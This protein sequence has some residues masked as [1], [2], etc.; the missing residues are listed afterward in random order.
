[1]TARW[2]AWLIASI[3]N[4]LGHCATSPGNMTF[5]VINSSITTRKLFVP[6]RFDLHRKSSS[7]SAPLPVLCGV[8]QGSVLGPIVFLLYTADLVQL[9]N[10]LTPRF[11][12]SVDPG[13]PTVYGNV[14]LTVSLPSLIGCIPINF[15]SMHPRW[16][17]CGAL[18]PIDEVSYLLIRWLLALISCRR[19]DACAISVFSLTLTWRCV[20]K[21][22]R[23]VQSVLLPFDNY[24][25]YPDL[26]QTT[27][28]SRSSWRWCFSGLTTALQLLPAF[29]SNSWTGF[30][31]YRMPLHGWSSKLVVRTT[32]SHY[33]AD[34]TGFGCQNASCSV[35]QCWCIA[36]STALRLATWLQIFSASHLNTRRWL[37]SSTASALVTPRTVHS[38]IGDC[39]FPATA[40]S[41]WNSLLESVLS[42]P[43]L[44]VFRSRLKTELFAQSYRHD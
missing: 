37:R 30:S 32:F 20:P 18:Q 9:V 42:L 11:T 17:Y 23:H 15:S 24:E 26:C 43:S 33:C 34:Y 38:A 28:C 5:T 2:P 40:A 39:T 44:Q 16:K 6:R 31:L 14:L 25:A 12:A 27:W 8:P 22:V 4:W 29:R 10:P 41:V 19:S 21:S 1:M 7:R 36:A 13:T 3:F 35:L